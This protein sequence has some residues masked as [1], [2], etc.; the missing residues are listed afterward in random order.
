MI[1]RFIL[2]LIQNLDAYFY[3]SGIENFRNL[4]RKD[5][6]HVTHTSNFSLKSI[7]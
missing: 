5:D 3:E 4:L 7:T 1:H 2:A 6:L